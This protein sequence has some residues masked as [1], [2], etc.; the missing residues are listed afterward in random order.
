MAAYPLEITIDNEGD[1]TNPRPLLYFG[2]EDDMADINYYEIK[3]GQGNNFKVLKE[4]TNPFRLPSQAPGTQVIVVR[5]L[6]QAGSFAEGTT[7]VKIESI[8]VPRVTVCPE[9]FVSGEEV[10]YLEGDALPNIRVIVFL[11]AP[12]S[13]EIYTLNPSGGL[14]ALALIL[15]LK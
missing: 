13:T 3:I 5:A 7:E 8:F 2:I 15:N 10:L 6:D 1:P 4:E 12:A 11:E 14:P 9:V